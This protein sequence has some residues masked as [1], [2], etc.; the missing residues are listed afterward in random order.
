M[1]DAQKP[2]PPP[3]ENAPPQD[4]NLTTDSAFH[5]GPTNGSDVGAL[6]SGSARSEEMR[7]VGQESARANITAGD[8]ASQSPLTT[9]INEQNRLSERLKRYARVTTVMG[10]LAAKLAGEKYLGL[11]IDRATHARDITAALGT[12]KGPLM[13]IAQ[14]LATV[15]DVLP[16]EYRAQLVALQA[17]APAMSWP[18]VRRRM[19]AELGPDWQSRFA[20]F[21]PEAASAASLGQVHRAVA[22]D[23]TALACKLQYPDMASAVEADLEQLKVLMALYEQWNPALKTAA[24]H[25][26]IGDRLREELDYQREARHIDLYRTIFAANPHVHVPTVRPEL[27]TQRLLTMTWLDGRRIA[28]LADAPQSYRDAIAK[29]LFCTWYKPFYTYGIIHGDPHPGNYT[30]ADDAGINLLDFGCIR[31]F[32]STFVQGVLELYRAIQTNDEDR[33]AHAYHIWGFSGLTKDHIAVLGLWARFL[34]EPLLDDR[35]RPLQEGNS[36]AYGVDVADRV[37]A[38]LRRIGGVQPPREFVFMDRAA[39]GIGSVIMTLGACCNWHRL[40]EELIAE[41]DAVALH[42]R[43]DSLLSTA[44]SMHTPA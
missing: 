31:L 7:V 38:E 27:S 20:S 1:S 9:S 40:Y 19:S 24:M 41:F 17:H 33:A 42:T 3:L 28:E 35:V 39:V 14:I 13:K 4:G 10:G 23:G 18:F 32:P 37:F 8:Q 22:H 16:P 29:N 44:G 15:P 21:T 12:L 11:R 36:G 43:Q 2:A 25:T 30:I 26:E 34:Y 6:S 5:E